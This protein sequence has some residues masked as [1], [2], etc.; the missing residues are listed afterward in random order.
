MIGLLAGTG[1]TVVARPAPAYVTLARPYLARPNLP[2]TALRRTALPWPALPWPVLAYATLAGAYLARPALAM[3]AVAMPALPRT[4]LSRPYLART[5]L[6]R[7]ALAR[8]ALAIAVPDTA[9]RNQ[10]DTTGLQA[11]HRMKDR[12]LDG[13][14]R[15]SLTIKGSCSSSPFPSSHSYRA[16]VA[17]G[18]EGPR[19]SSVASC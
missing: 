6:C 1:S 13:C 17:G 16:G 11:K 10:L 5:A 8:T 19:V 7:T 3:T 4:A 12:K 2:W 9:T 18:M 14:H 15:S